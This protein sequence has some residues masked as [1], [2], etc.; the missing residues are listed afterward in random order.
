MRDDQ[1]VLRELV[2]T[3]FTMPTRVSRVSEAGE[4]I[5]V[6]R[7]F[8]RIKTVLADHE[9]NIYVWANPPEIGPGSRTTLY[10]LKPVLAE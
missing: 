4:V 6:A 10:K 2:I 5:D 7:A 3:G 1:L 8:S 9:G